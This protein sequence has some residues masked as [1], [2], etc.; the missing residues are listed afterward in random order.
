MT[1]LLFGRKTFEGPGVGTGHEVRLQEG[2][3]LLRGEGTPVA[4]LVLSCVVPSA[5]F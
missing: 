2:T 5:I 3:G 4:V 1:W